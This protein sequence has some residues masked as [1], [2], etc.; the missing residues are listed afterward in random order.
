MASEAQLR[1]VLGR[2]T[3]LMI[4]GRCTAAVDAATWYPCSFAL[5]APELAGNAGDGWAAVSGWRGN[6]GLTLHRADGAAPGV[7]SVRAIS[8]P[9][10]AALHAQAG[11]VPA[12]PFA[13]L[14]GVLAPPRWLD[15]RAPTYGAKLA[16]R[17]RADSNEAMRSNV[18]RASGTVTLRSD[19]GAP[20]AGTPA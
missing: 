2:L 12:D 17:F 10:A 5:A 8:M 18:D 16:F 20:K 4:G 6:S 14:L 15:D 3:M 9:R 1:A 11:V 19:P 7:A 13:G